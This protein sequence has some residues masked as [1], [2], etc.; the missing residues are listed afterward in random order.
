MDEMLKMMEKLLHWAAI[1]E[2]SDDA[3][4]SKSADGYI[5]SWNKGAQNL[6]GYKPSEIVGKPVSVLMPPGKQDDFPYIMGQLHAGKKIEHYETKRV[7]KDGRIL[8][9]SITVSPIRDSSGHII[10]ASKIARDVTERVEYERRRDD[11]VSTASHELKTPLTSQLAFGELLE[12]MIDRNGNAEYKP[13]I[14]KINEQT[15]KLIGLVED[16]LI[17]SRLRGGRL[18]IENKLFSIHKVVKQ[19]VESL[20]L[21]TKHDIELRGKTERKV[22]GDSNRIGQVVTNL[23]SN[24][25]KYSPKADKIVV[26]VAEKNG[27]AVISIQDFGIGIPNEYHGKI[28]ERFFR[29]SDTDERTYPGMGIG[30]NF[31]KD[32]IERHHGKIWLASKKG[33]GSTFYFSLPFAHGK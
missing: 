20:Q 29:V 11:F 33:E 18:P 9:V 31:C 23:L 25:I 6:Y 1:V 27:F 22:R 10:G 26:K 14:R 28:F 30:L 3:I 5:T 32:I 13:Y 4:I 2:S 15:G 12:E 17:L 24:G 16:L 7:T 19:A 21:T 8:D